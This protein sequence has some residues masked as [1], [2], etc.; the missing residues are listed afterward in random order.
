MTASSDYPPACHSASS[1]LLAA[2][3]TLAR[4]AIFTVVGCPFSAAAGEPHWSYR[5]IVRP[6]TPTTRQHE[7]ARSAIDRFIAARLEREGLAPSAEADPATLIRRLSLD[8]IGLPPT[9]DEVRQFLRDER[10][11]AYERLV[12]RLLTSPHYGERW[13]RAWLDLCH[14]GDSDGHLTDQLRPVA[15]RYRDWLVRAL[16]ANMPFDEFT[17]LQLAG[18]VRRTGFQHAQNTSQP[19]GHSGQGGSLRYDESVLGTGFLRQTLSNREGGADLEE[20]RVE[21]VVDRTS[22]VGS[23]WLGL[24]VGCARCHDHK[25]DLVTQ[26]EFYRLYAFFDQADEVNIDAPLPEERE[27]GSAHGRSMNAAA[28]SLSSRYARRSMTCRSSGRRNCC[29]RPP[30]P[31][32]TTSGTGSGKCWA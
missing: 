30:I 31:A 19:D 22:L 21:Q 7:W 28:S 20:Y 15:W 27:R 18:D 10:P 23:I 3:S 6:K 4:I 17:V 2:V 29:M 25:Y 9:P 1:R 24:T 5:P 11:E 14:Y 8:L 12:D 13:A 16:N 26:E 32:R